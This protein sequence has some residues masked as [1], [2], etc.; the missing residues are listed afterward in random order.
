L[1]TALN[2]RMAN[3]SNTPDVPE[4]A[5]IIVRPMANLVL[6]SVVLDRLLLQAEAA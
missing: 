1:L 5:R 4:A 3:R 6:R 2:P